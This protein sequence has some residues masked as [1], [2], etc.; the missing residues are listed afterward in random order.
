MSELARNLRTLCS[1]RPSISQVGRDLGINRSQLNRYLAGRSAPRLPLLRRIC[2]Y[3]GVE[4]HEMLLPAEEFEEIVKL[5]GLDTDDLSRQ[6]RHHFNSIMTLNDPRFRRLSGSFFEYHYSMAQR[7]KI[8]RSLITFTLHSDHMTYRRLERM[9]HFDRPCTRHYRY[10]GLALMTGERVFMNDYEY[11]A[12]IELTQT[13]L[14][15][16]YSMRWTRL[17]G[18][19]VGVS[20]NQYHSP[21]CVRVFLERVPTDMPVLSA[22]RRCGLYAADHPAI[23]A[24]IRDQIDNSVSGPYAFDAFVKDDL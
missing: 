9:G 11:G 17:N 23:P 21:C 19:K 2:D 3:F 20:A 15:P 1:Y 5:K 13:V 22:L 10:Q 4:P 6:L 8:L 24:D 12:G 7:G 16:D 14:Y 18:L